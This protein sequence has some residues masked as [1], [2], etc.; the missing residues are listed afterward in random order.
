VRIKNGFAI[1]RFIIIGVLA[2]GIGVPTAAARSGPPRPDVPPVPINLEVPEGH[3][4]YLA[5]Y[6]LG[7]QNYICM[8]APSASGVVWRFLGPQATL[9]R[10]TP[11]EPRLQLTTH[12]LS[13]NPVEHLARPTWQ[14]STDSSRVWGRVKASS[15]DPNYVEPG[16][17]DWLLVE[18]AGSE[19]GPIGRGVLTQTTFI[20]RLNTTG[21]T[22]PIAGCS[23]ATQIGTLA[24]VPYSTDYLFYRASRAR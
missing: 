18:V 22:A 19:A 2:L 7:T 12:Y 21:G 9:F 15:N 4:L 17:I 3:E 14:H 5:G 11:G 10:M 23:D 6:A 16:A 13:V 24:L 8:P 20:H 1:V